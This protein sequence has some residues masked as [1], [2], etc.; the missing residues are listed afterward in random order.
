M[1]FSHRQMVESDLEAV[2]ELYR[3]VYERDIAKGTFMW[4]YAS[5]PLLS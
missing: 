3:R 5:N 2:L 4:Q 1:E